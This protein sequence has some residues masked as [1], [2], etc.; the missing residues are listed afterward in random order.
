MTL[1]EQYSMALETTLLILPLAIHILTVFHLIITKRLPL[2][3]IYK[4]VMRSLSVGLM[5]PVLMY[6]LI[7]EVMSPVCTH[8]YMK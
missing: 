3:I 6:L 4:L 8:L 5:S 2:Y 7:D 1:P